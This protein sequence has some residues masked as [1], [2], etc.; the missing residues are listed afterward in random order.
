MTG[1]VFDSLGDRP[2]IG[3][4]VQLL[5]APPG[6]SSYSAITDAIGRFQIDSVRAGSYIAGF[7]HPLLDTLGV[8]AP[9]Q[10]LTV[11]AGGTSRVTLAVPAEPRLARAICGDALGANDGT[12]TKDSVGILVGH[13]RDAN[14]GAP[15]SG[16]AVTLQWKEL[17]F[18]SGGPHTETHELRAS[19][20][21]EGWFALC[22]LIASDYQLHADRGARTTGLIDLDVHAREI[23]RLSIL[24]GADANAAVAD[25]AAKGGASLSGLV[26]TSDGHPLEGAQ[27]LVDGSAATAT[28]D[29]RGAFALTGLADGTRMSEARAL[30]YEP[31]RVRVELSR[32]ELARV[33]IVMGRRVQTLDAVKVIARQRERDQ[34]LAGFIQRRK[35]G[36]GRYMTKE[37]IEQRNVQNACDLL[38]RIPGVHVMEDG[39]GQCKANIRGATTGATPVG[40]PAAPHLCE[41]SIY[42][43][44]V[45]FGGTLAEFAKLVPA[46]DIVG[47]EVYTTSTVPPQFMGACGVIVIWTRSGT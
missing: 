47:I 26:T 29:A 41:P 8:N 14:T 31:R 7:L 46:S 36:E 20:T 13:V 6:R 40:T 32:A 10:N 30:G 23:A 37:E 15:V 25:T 1:T 33:T 12:A 19:T 35:R 4:T 2:L 18:G 3:A 22:G 44:N 9:Y 42:E 27:V 21:S 28:T 43:D 34:N 38:R 11:A 45:P 39:S 5:E 17:I 16:S 24:L